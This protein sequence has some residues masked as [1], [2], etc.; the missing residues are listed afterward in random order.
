MLRLPAVC[1]TAILAFAPLFCKRVFPY[2][3]TLLLGAILAPAQRTVTACLRVM[4]LATEDNF[5]N[6][7]RVLNRA[8]WSPLRASRVLL[9][10]VLNRFAGDRPLVF[11]LD[12][13]LERR[14]GEKIRAKGIYRDAVRSSR[15]HFAKAS[16]LRWLSLSL[17]T[18]VPWSPRR[19]AL[20]VLTVLAP[21]ERYHRECGRR[22]KKLTD[23][24]R[25]ILLLIGRWLPERA[26]IIVCDSSFAAL[27][28]LGAVRSSVTMITR[29]RLDA[30]LYKPAPGRKR[31]TMG[32]PRSKGA[33]LPK[34]ATLLKDRRQQWRRVCLQR[35][36]SQNNR[37]V[38]LLSGTAVWYHCG[39]PVVPIRWVLVRDPLGRF[40][41]QAFLS[42]DLQMTPEQILEYYVD[43]WQVEVTF[44]EVRQHLGVETQRQWSDLAI[45]RTTPV[46]FGLYSL[47]TLMAADLAEEGKLTAR[48]AAWYDKEHKTFSDALASVRSAMWTSR[49]FSMSRFRRD[50]VKIPK[51]LYDALVCT[52][53]Y[54]S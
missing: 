47:V 24:A 12:D 35:W 27:E 19:W 20:P 39:L 38:E 29:L 3:E 1:A 48:R 54:A 31:S 40:E 14:R 43:R 51:P 28:L 8:K 41:P 15:T 26:I 32:R 4:G 2:A 49:S 42:T 5:Q 53:A 10:L 6:Y 44:E 18:P 9:D 23:W 21:S 30:A 34:L 52:L 50:T 37:E 45:A 25:Q 7:H 16:G 22:H 33:A 17:I 13:T 46:L 36:Y 11:G